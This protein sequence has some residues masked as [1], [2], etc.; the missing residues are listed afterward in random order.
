MLIDSKSGRY[1]LLT[2]FLVVF[3]VSCRCLK[4]APP[5]SSFVGG[6]DLSLSRLR[7]ASAVNAATAV[8]KLA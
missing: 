5:S 4:S 7:W 3:T 2:Q 8:D 1:L 6:S